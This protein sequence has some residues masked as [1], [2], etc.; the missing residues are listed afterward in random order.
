MKYKKNNAI[1]WLILYLT[2]PVYAEE[3]LPFNLYEI[4]ADRVLGEH[5]TILI[6]GGIHGNEPGSYFA[7]ALFVQHYT[8]TKGGAWVIPALNKPSIIKNARGVYG[9]MNRKFKTVKKSDKDYAKVQAIKQLITDKKVGLVLNLHDGHG[10][11]RTKWKGKLFNPIAWGQASVIDQEQLTTAAKYKNLYEIAVQVSEEVNKNININYH[12]FRVKNTQ[13]KEKDPTQQNSLTYFAVQNHKP[14][15]AIETSKNIDDLSLKVLYQLRTIEAYMKI[16]GI[17]YE[18]DF[19]L[20]LKTLSKLLKNYGHITINNNIKLPLSNMRRHMKFAP[21]KKRGND[22]EFSHPLGGVSFSRGLYHLHIGN[23]HIATLSPQYFHL[24]EHKD[25]ITIEVDGT[26]KEV[27]IGDNVVTKQYFK[28]KAPD[29]RVN[30]IG[31]GDRT[32]GFKKVYRRNILSYFSI[33][34]AKKIYRSEF[35]KGKRFVGMITIQ[36][37]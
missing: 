27:F 24:L 15:F 29:F 34:S 14:A 21:L 18:R 13:T 26:D 23:K 35:Y 17:R 22:F 3:K 28:I 7:P 4:S 20:N 9:D 2:L 6:V 32:D 16:M 33:D 30:V 8:I 5:S 11:F 31:Y 12:T 36:F 19:E 25:P 1:L 37:K 10:F